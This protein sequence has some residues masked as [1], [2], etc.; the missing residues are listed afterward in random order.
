MNPQE[1]CDV[2]G[3]GFPYGAGF[4][5]LRTPYRS[6]EFK[7]LCTDC[8]YVISEFKD[9]KMDEALKEVAVAVQ[10]KLK[11]MSDD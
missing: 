10:A 7:D 5:T 11:E 3:K 4:Q 6:D 2:C 1:Y 9:K 8:M